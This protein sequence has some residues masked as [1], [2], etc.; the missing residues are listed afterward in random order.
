[1]HLTK[2]SKS[3]YGRRTRPANHWINASASIAIGWLEYQEARRRPC[4]AAFPSRK[5]TRTIR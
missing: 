1:M 5:L 2:E 3:Y 4:A